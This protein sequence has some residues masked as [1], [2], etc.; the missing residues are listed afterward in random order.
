MT[1]LERTKAIELLKA[2]MSLTMDEWLTEA[3]IGRDDLKWARKFYRSIEDIKDDAMDDFQ[4]A[5]KEKPVAVL[6][7]ETLHKEI[8]SESIDARAFDED[9][10]QEDIDQRRAEGVKETERLLRHI[11][12]TE[13]EIAEH[14]RILQHGN[15]QTYFHTLIDYEKLSQECLNFLSKE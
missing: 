11:Q 9:D 1:D 2:N 8:K 15:W 4:D 12:E 14:D 10:T 5:Q 13:D 7:L 3:S 6:E